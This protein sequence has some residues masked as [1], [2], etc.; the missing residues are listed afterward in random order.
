MSA[1]LFMTTL[2][3]HGQGTFVYDQQSSTFEGVAG[4]T[5]IQQSQPFA[6]SFIPTLSSV[7]FIRLKLS[8][9]NPG[10]GVGVTMYVNLSSNSIPGTPFAVTQP[11]TLPN[12]F[13]GTVNF[14]FS[15]S[16]SLT[17]AVTYFFQPVVSS[18]DL[19]NIDVEEFNYPNGTIYFNGLPLGG[20][21]DVWFREG[22]VVP[23]PSSVLLGL[24][25]IGAFFVCRANRNANPPKL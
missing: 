21:S 12:A 8:N 3:A 13:A 22:I 1:T 25:G 7:D 17:S 16:V 20:M 10:S 19:W 14:F 18:G 9:N 11:V 23:E 2:F 5:I 24:I 15:T 6:Q 4:N